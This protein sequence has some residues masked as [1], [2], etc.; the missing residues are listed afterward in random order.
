MPDTER[1]AYALSA[2]A[3]LLES[4][5]RK[6]SESDY[7]ETITLARDSMR[8]ASSAVLFL[9]GKV[10]PDLETS[11][12]YLREKYG[13]VV[14]VEE[15]QEVEQLSRIGVIG[16]LAGMFGGAKRLQKDAEKALGAAARF[17]GATSAIVDQSVQGQKAAEDAGEQEGGGQESPEAGGEG[18]VPAEEETE[19]QPAGPE[20]EPFGEAS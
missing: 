3:G 10:A 20:E 8:I 5:E 19:A 14:K 7:G 13:D 15:W 6:N 1:A 2:A 11:C 16:R 4:A 17:F 18:E 12:R 9:D